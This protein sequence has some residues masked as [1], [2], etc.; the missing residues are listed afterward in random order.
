MEIIVDCKN[1]TRF[2][3]IVCEENRRKITFINSERKLISKIKVDGCQIT[4]GLRCDYL[5]TLE[6]LENYV[7]LKG[8][9]LRHAFRQIIRTILL[10]GR[11]NTSRHSYVISSRSPLSAAE[12]QHFRL[13][14]RKNYQSDLVVKN[15]NFEVII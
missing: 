10:L 15:N 12:I 2:P 13:K 9:D 3:R 8:H 11:E 6:N 7:E 1:E 14:L 4:D 5:L